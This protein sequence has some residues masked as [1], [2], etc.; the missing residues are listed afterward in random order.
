MAAPPTVS[1]RRVSPVAA[2][3][4]I[5][6]LHLLA[7]ASPGPNVLLVIHTAVSRS[8]RSALAAAVGVATGAAVLAATAVLGLSVVFEQVD[9]IRTVIQLAGA[10]Y[11]IF[12]GAQVFRG[13]PEPL[14]E[15]VDDAAAGG[16]WRYW[17]RGLLTNLTNPKAAIFYG[18]VLA[19][20]L[21][22]DLPVWARIAAVVLIAVDT[23]AWHALLAVVFARP[24]PQRAYRRAKTGVDRVVGVGLAAFGVQFAIS[25]P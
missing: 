22:P 8:R 18:S 7:M 20:A 13:A 17:R 23:T 6:A 5:A 4:S 3:A 24:T 15:P 2:L 16:A 10:A 9:W 19:T 1:S 21:T 12:L 14:P 25:R 11:L